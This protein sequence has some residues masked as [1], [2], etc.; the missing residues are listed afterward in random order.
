M[1]TT[2]RIGERAARESAARRLR[3]NV[4][5]P[6]LLPRPNFLPVCPAFLAARMTCPTKL[7]GRWAPQFPC[8]MR[9]GRTLISSSRTVMAIG[10]RKTM[11][12]GARCVEF[13]E[14]C[15]VSASKR[16]CPHAQNSQSNQPHAPDGGRGFYL[17]IRGWY[18]PAPT[19][20]HQNTRWQRQIAMKI[21]RSRLTGMVHNKLPDCGTRADRS[22]TGRT[23]DDRSGRAPG[24]GRLSEELRAERPT[25][26]GERAIVSD[27]ATATI[28]PLTRLPSIIGASIAT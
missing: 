14:V 19:A 1:T 27:S 24:P 4:E 18:L 10:T 20:S 6:L 3:P 9:P 21:M 15:E 17:A 26:S 23:F 16:P 11:T 13:L 2:R 5:L 28:F 8:R 22:T 25:N 12:A 7:F